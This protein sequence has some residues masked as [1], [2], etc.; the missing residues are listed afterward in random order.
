MRPRKIIK[1]LML[2]KLLKRLPL[3][4]V[5]P[6]G[7]VALLLGSL[8]TSVRALGRVKRLERRLAGTPA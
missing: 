7:P 4:P 5:I 6:L 8:I 1:G 3:F 2:Y